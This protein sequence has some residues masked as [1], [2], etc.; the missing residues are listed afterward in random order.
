LYDIQ[1]L[2]LLTNMML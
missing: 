2:R 1:L